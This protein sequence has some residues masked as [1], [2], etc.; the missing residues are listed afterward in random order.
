VSAILL[1]KLVVQ[2]LHANIKLIFDKILS[3]IYKNLKYRAFLCVKTKVLTARGTLKN[4]KNTHTQSSFQWLYTVT[5]FTS[6][7]FIYFLPSDS[8]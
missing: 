7:D 8:G 3:L 4:L 6:G 2:L 1:S 5:Q